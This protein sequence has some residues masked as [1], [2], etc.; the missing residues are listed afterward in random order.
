V[1]AH[2]LRFRFKEETSQ[3]EFEAAMAAFRRTG[4]VPTISSA[5]VGRYAGNPADGFTHSAVY[6]LADLATLERFMYEP[7]H[8]EADFVVHPL[9]ASMDAF[10]ISDDDEPDLDAK[11]MDIQ[12]RRLAADPEL[13]E[14]LGIVAES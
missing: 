9:I 10:D 14:L 13:A 2:V 4:Q 12:Q 5:I 3:E 7:V 1:I 6:V 11:I 8:R